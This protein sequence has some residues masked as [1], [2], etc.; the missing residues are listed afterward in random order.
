[1]KNNLPIAKTEDIVVQE[2]PKEILIYNLR[3]NKAFCL[4]PTLSL[5]W[6]H[7][8]GKTDVPQIIKHF[9]NEMSL[10]VDPDFVF[11]ALDELRKTELI[12]NYQPKFDDRISRRKVLLSYALPM[13]MLPV[14]TSIVA[15]LAVQ[16]ASGAV[17]VANPALTCSTDSDCIP[18]FTPL[19]PQCSTPGINCAIVC[20]PTNC[21]ELFE[22]IE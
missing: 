1:M 16:A 10:Q 13:A 4:N 15:P 12:S 11:L 5:V 19:P 21:C 20:L 18:I 14:V 8:D 22:N 9:E 3:E 2:L 6:K 17:C 7:C